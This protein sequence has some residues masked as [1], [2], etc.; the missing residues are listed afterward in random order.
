MFRSALSKSVLNAPRAGRSEVRSVL[1]RG[2]HEKVISHYESP[3][4]VVFFHSEAHGSCYLI[5]K[6]LGGFSEQ[7]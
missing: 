6:F 2:Y 4:N 7:E 3:R 5:P 1:A